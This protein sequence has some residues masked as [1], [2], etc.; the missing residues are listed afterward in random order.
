MTDI[1]N[2]Q[3]ETGTEDAFGVVV[4]GLGFVGGGVVDLVGVVGGPFITANIVDEGGVVVGVVGVVDSGDGADGVL[5]GVGAGVA[6]LLGGTVEAGGPVG[7]AAELGSRFEIPTETR[8]WDTTEGV[9]GVVF[10]SGTDRRTPNT[11]N[12]TPDTGGVVDGG[13][14]GVPGVSSSGSGVGAGLDK[15]VNVALDVSVE[16]GRAKVTLADVLDYDVGSVVELDR[17]AGAPVDVRVNDTLLAQ[18]EVV[19]IDDEYAVRITAIIDPHT[20]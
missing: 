15:L 16:L 7:A 6:G 4:G 8:V 19:L 9:T 2:T 3:V 14:A 1:E 11:P 18:G 5:G 13:V 17:A 10:V 20:P 12:N